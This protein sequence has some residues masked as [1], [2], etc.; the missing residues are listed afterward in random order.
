MFLLDQQKLFSIFF[1]YRNLSWAIRLYVIVFVI[2]VNR[3]D[4]RYFIIPVLYWVGIFLFSDIREPDVWVDKNEVVKTFE[5]RIR[6]ISLQRPP[7]L[8]PPSKRRSL[9]SPPPATT[10]WSSTPSATGVR[11]FSSLSSLFRSSFTSGCTFAP[12]TGRPVTYVVKQN[13]NVC[14]RVE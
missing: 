14:V 10:L 1:N 12:E 9:A 13:P 2:V 5:I 4:S 11:A 8:F 7:L 6:C 3:F